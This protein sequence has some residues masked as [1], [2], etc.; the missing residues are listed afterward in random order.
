VSS[1]QLLF[2]TIDKLDKSQLIVINEARFCR[3]DV[4]R[5]SV[6]PTLKAAALA[7][8]QAFAKKKSVVHALSS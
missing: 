1:I 5:T 7:Q 4:T 2:D 8:W 6:K 3:G